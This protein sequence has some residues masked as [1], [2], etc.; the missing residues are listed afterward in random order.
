MENE[1][2]IKRTAE[3]YAGTLEDLKHKKRGESSLIIRGRYK[4]ALGEIILN[5][6][7]DGTNERPEQFT[8][9]D[10][11]TAI[12]Q[13]WGRE[14]RDYEYDGHRRDPNGNFVEELLDGYIRH[15]MRVEKS[16][17]GYRRKIF[18]VLKEV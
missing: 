18:D 10:I 16:N 17:E 4:A 13:A 11:L 15:D 1:K 6:F 2:N 14:F 9:R 7:L 8:K 3:D 5:E 12:H